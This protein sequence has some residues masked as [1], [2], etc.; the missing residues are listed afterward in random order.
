MTARFTS[1]A[2]TAPGP[3]PTSTGAQQP[4]YWGGGHFLYSTL[5][6]APTLKPS[7]VMRRVS[8][9]PFGLVAN[10]LALARPAAP[11]GLTVPLSAA[12]DEVTELALPVVTVGG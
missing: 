12:E 3:Q 11:F 2:R 8:P 10:P 9:V 7:L 6:R 5:T 1:A 4:D